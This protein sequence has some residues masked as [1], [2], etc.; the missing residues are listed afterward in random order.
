[1]IGAI[2]AGMVYVA[3]NTQIN[4]L[5]VGLMSYFKVLVSFLICVI[6]LINYF[7]GNGWSSILGVTLF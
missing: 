7:W 5:N 3:P 2:V 4:L 6:K 1:M